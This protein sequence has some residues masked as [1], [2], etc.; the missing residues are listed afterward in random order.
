MPLLLS[1]AACSAVMGAAVAVGGQMLIRPSIPVC[2]GHC[3]GEIK[4]VWI[5]SASLD[6]EFSI[7]PLLRSSSWYKQTRE[8]TL[9]YCLIFVVHN[10]YIM[11]TSRNKGTEC[12]PHLL[13]LWG[14]EGSTEE[15]NTGRRAGTMESECWLQVPMCSD[16]VT[17]SLPCSCTVILPAKPVIFPQKLDFELTAFEIEMEEDK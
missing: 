10:H 8:H 3:S 17:C 6:H 16:T 5:S 15:C 9:D 14:T 13:I 4:L 1:D 7:S 11:L 12:N 2:C